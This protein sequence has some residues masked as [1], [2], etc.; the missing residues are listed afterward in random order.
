MNK[1]FKCCKNK[2]F[3]NYCCIVCLSVFH[4]ACLDR[5]KSVV[6][7]G[8]YKI[9]CSLECQSR[10]ETEREKVASYNAEIDRLKSECQDKDLLINQLKRQ[11]QQFERDVVDTERSYTDSLTRQD[12]VI[13]TLRKQLDEFKSKNSELLS[14]VENAKEIEDRIRKDLEEMTGVN[15]NM[16]E[17]IRVLEQDNHFCAGELERVRDELAELRNGKVLAMDG[18]CEVQTTRRGLN[19]NLGAQVETADVVVK[20]VVKGKRLLIVSDQS[21]YKIRSKLSKHLPGF[22]IQS[23]VK[24]YAFYEN[25]VEDV[26]NLSQ[27]LG[28]DDCILVMAGV[29]NFAQKRYPSFRELNRRLKCITH[30]NVVLTS[31]LP[32]NNANRTCTRLVSKCNKALKEYAARL[33]RYAYGRVSFVDLVSSNAS[34]PILRLAEGVLARKSVVDRNLVFIQTSDAPPQSDVG[35]LSP[36]CNQVAEKDPILISEEALESEPS[37]CGLAGF[38]RE[39]EGTEN[40]PSE[41]PVSLQQDT[42]SGSY[43]GDQ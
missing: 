16:V 17:S 42:S 34:G 9:Y 7:L 12:E 26:V 10:E 6:K 20:Q 21:G 33:D 5:N 28:D 43:S 31:V 24:P 8:A 2:D 18:C 25:V 4:P 37:E 19:K 29:N 13:S 39:G 35:G 32:P 30:T 14:E 38:F 41:Y 36:H 22:S 11:S 23:I 3:A 40:N 1:R 27:Q 15:R